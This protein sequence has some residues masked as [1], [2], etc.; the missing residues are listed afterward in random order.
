MDSKEN[1]H[2]EKNEVINASLVMFSVV[3]WILKHNC[4]LIQYLYEWGKALFWNTWCE[5][6]PQHYICQSER[7]YLICI[8]TTQEVKLKTFESFRFL[9]RTK[10]KRSF[11]Q[12]EKNA[13]CFDLLVMVIVC[14]RGHYLI[15]LIRN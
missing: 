8:V 9:V 11:H 14:W 3:I 12:V 5:K 2:L 7:S 10:K 1:F 6:K 15:A 4:R 13:T